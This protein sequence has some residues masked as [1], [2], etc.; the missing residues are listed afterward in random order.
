M[1]LPLLIVLVAIGAGYLA[2]GRLRGFEALHL[3]WWLLA[4]LGL[5]MQLAP[6]PTD[7]DP[8]REAIAA[9]V[10]VASFPVLLLFLG[11]NR[12]VPGFALI[13]VGLVLNLVV[14]A[15]NGGMPVSPSAIRTAGGTEADVQELA[16]S[17]DV[18]HHVRGEDDVLAVIGDTIPIAPL[19]TV[20]SLGDLVAYAGAAWVVIGAMLRPAPRRED[21]PSTHRPA[22][23][24]RGK[25]RPGALPAAEPRR[26][27]RSRPVPAAA[28]RSGT[29]P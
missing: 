8:V 14:I 27:G 10:L 2:G 18:K 29:A 15:P 3:R 17:A 26:R 16:G 9:G 5:A 20:V 21:P 7:G 28:A 12:R 13:F 4:P 11:V 25:H 22:R 19:G 23:G 24:Y 1:L 6:I